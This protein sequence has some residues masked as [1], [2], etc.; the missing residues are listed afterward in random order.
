MKTVKRTLFTLFIIV[1]ILSLVSCSIVGQG[2]SD[3][4]LYDVDTSH[5]TLLDPT[6]EPMHDAIR[7]AFE[8]DISIVSHTV[9][10]TLRDVAGE[11]IKSETVSEELA[12]KRGDTISHY[13]NAAD[14]EL[15]ATAEIRVNAKSYDNPENYDTK[16]L[17]RVTFYANGTVW[18]SALSRGGEP[19][20]SP[21]M[22]SNES[23]IFAGW[24]LDQDYKTPFDFSGNY[25]SDVSV[26]ARFISS[27][28]NIINEVTTRIMPSVVTIRATQYKYQ[29]FSKVSQSSTS[30]G[31]I[32]NYEGNTL[33]MTNCHSV[34]LKSGY[35]SMTIAVEDYLG[36]LYDAEIL[37]INGNR[38][39]SAEYDLALLSVSGLSGLPALEFAESN[40]EIG[41]EIIS[42]GSP[43]GQKNAVTFGIVGNF[44]IISIDIEENLSNV[45][46]PV[47]HHSAP[48]KAGSSGGCVLNT[49]LDV[50]G[51]NFAG[52][53]GD[54]FTDGY[55]IPLDKILAFLDTI[56]S[57]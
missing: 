27:K 40:A 29:G 26:Y 32:V 52:A 13:V 30:S 18:A 15:V 41:D 8:T 46:F 17:P 16:S 54:D 1:F 34:E 43:S 39:I 23:S 37:T 19:I 48:I 44:N 35:S 7:I 45:K 20:L 22:P 38:A 28:D 57:K 55:A 5:F 31:F 6:Y 47:I 50:V 33:V 53:E 36:N 25:A 56:Q 51:V 11:Q 2:N 4:T 21:D 14:K 49:D 9:T 42:I 24:Y 3:D 10:I 12:Y